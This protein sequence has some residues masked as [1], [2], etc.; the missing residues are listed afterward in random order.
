MKLKYYEIHWS[1]TVFVEYIDTE[2]VSKPENRF[3]KDIRYISHDNDIIKVSICG[4]DLD[5]YASD[6]EEDRQIITLDRNLEKAK[7]K[8][9]KNL[10]EHKV[11][12]D[13]QIERVKSFKDEAI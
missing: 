7:E 11:E 12:I 5:G 3:T 1:G 10:E 6:N 9:T 13:K 2:Q 4:T 8:F